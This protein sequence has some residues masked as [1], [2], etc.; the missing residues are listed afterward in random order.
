MVCSRLARRSSITWYLHE[1]RHGK[2][3]KQ[4]LREQEKTRYENAAAE[5]QKQ[6]LREQERTGDANGAEAQA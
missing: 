3:Q 6:Q 5:Q 1:R 4:Q 2:Q